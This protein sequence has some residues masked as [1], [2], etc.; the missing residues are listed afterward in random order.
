M[1]LKIREHN[2][3]FLVEGVINVNTIEQFKNHIE[4]L[5]VYTKSLTLNIDNVT[6]IDREGVN[7][8]KSFFT[9]AKFYEKDF[10]VTGYGSK[11]IYN[12][13]QQPEEIKI[14]Q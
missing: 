3:E 9:K 6:A 4:F 10:T 14:I 11:D 13:L 12:A 8:I 7:L 2:G 1:S 5:M